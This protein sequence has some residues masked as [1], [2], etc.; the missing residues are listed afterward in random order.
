[1]SGI[2]IIASS[3]LGVESV[4][5]LLGYLVVELLEGLDA[6]RRRRRQLLAVI[7]LVLD[8]L[9]GGAG[10]DLLAVLVLIVLDGGGLG[11]DG[12]G[13]L[14]QRLHVDDAHAEDGS[15][16]LVAVSVGRLVDGHCVVA[17]YLRQRDREI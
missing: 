16:R 12:L 8:R 6:A 17:D 14:V 9:V 3:R 13:R 10:D 7:V 1:M 15:S 5:L 11:A 4:D 2:N